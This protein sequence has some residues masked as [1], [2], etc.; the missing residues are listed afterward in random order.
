MDVSGLFS[1]LSTEAQ[2][3][4]WAFVYLTS[5]ALSASYVVMKN[6]QYRYPRFRIPLQVVDALVGTA[7]AIY[8]GLHSH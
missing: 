5:L 7:P 8:T 4:T 3:G 6:P 2:G 1:D